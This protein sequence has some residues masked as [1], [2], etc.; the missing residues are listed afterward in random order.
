MRTKT[1]TAAIVALAASAVTLAACGS[2]SKQQAAAQGPTGVTGPTEVALEPVGKPTHNPFTTP[3]GKDKKRVKPP[4]KAAS[5]TGGVATYSGN[6][7]G[8]YGGTR[9]YATCN[10]SQMVSFLE[11]NYDKAL[12]WSR[13]LGIEV[14][15]IRSYVSNLTPVILRTDTRVTNHGYLNGTATAIQSV[16]QAGTA[17]F[18]NSY[19]QPVV[20]CYCGNPL[21][22]AVAAFRPVYTGIQW[23]NFSTTHITIIQKSVTIID[24][25]TLYDPRTGTTFK[26][27]A[28]TDGSDDSPYAGSQPQ[29]P[30]ATPTPQAPAPAAPQAPPP[31]A[32]QAPPTST[33]AP[34]PPPESPAASW[35][36]NPGHLGEEFTLSVSGFASDK[37][38]VFELLRP[39]GVLEHY[40]I[41]SDSSGHGSYT[42]TNTGGSISGTYTAT[43]VDPDTHAQTSSSV[44]VLP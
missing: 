10:A 32:P 13:T 39:D 22:P 35:S 42:F 37:D 24:N 25:F 23:V 40:R 38:L 11:Q 26:R 15:D 21:T 41:H 2:A 19:G 44:Q 5:P 4:R 36:P 31:A 43:V 20:K 12:A 17:V 16:L 34:Q 18:V 14:S 30:A 33:Q 28:G 8:L 9:N 1:C 3:V 7:P 27:P 6:L 29:Q